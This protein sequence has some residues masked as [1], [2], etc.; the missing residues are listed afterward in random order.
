MTTTKVV[1]APST[2]RWTEWL[3][4]RD[5]GDYVLAFDDARQKS[6]FYSVM[7]RENALLGW[8][9]YSVQAD[10]L[11]VSLAVKDREVRNG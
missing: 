8:R 3:R 1:A 2:N 10:G 6:V 11:S 5:V 7:Y 4:A 9:R